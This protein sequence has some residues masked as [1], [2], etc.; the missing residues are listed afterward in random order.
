MLDLMGSAYV[1]EHVVAEHDKRMQE[2]AY[3]IYMSDL[4]MCLVESFGG[5][6]TRRYA[7]IISNEPV[8]E[9]TGDEVALEVIRRLGLKVKGGGESL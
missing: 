3:R 4:A 7:D 9:K 1:I 2:K 6:V 5:E 8:N